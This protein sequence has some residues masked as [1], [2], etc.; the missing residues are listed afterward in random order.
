MLQVVPSQGFQVLPGGTYTLRISVADAN[1]GLV[2]SVVMLPVGGLKLLATPSIYTGGPYAVVSHCRKA[3]AGAWQ[4]HQPHVQTAEQ[5]ALQQHQR[6]QAE[7]QMCSEQQ[8][9]SH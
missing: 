3:A 8:T 5:I 6:L 9:H 1:N 7:G 4:Q 2:D